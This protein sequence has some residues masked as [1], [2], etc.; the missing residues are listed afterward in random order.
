MGSRSRPTY[1][2]STYSW[3]LF[4]AAN[5]KLDTCSVRLQ[6]ILLCLVVC[7]CA[8][9]FV[10]MWLH[11]QLPVYL[12][13]VY[14]KQLGWT[15]ADSCELNRD[16]ILL[17]F[18]TQT[19][20]VSFSITLHGVVFGTGGGKECNGGW[21]RRKGGGKEGRADVVMEQEVYIE[22]IKFHTR[23]LIYYVYTKTTGKIGQVSC[24]LPT[25]TRSFM[26]NTF[27]NILSVVE[28][29]TFHFP[30][31]KSIYVHLYNLYAVRV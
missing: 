24:V 31:G 17:L 23:C 14:C 10:C 20:K 28:T 21:L 26:T 7:M 2:S 11:Q 13:W 5:E 1:T 4:E 16:R 18:C 30:F 22:M 15:Y 25:L 29:C 19:V 27:T 8:C 3:L 9:Q 12:S 6:K